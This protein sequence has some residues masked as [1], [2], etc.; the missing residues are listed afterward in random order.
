MKIQ[1]KRTNGTLIA[2]S[3]TLTLKELVENNKANLV[4]A[5]LGGADLVD[6]NLVGAD[7]EDAYLE[8]A[9]LEGADLGSANL[10]GAYLVSANLG[11]ANLVNANLGGAYLVNAN[12]VNANLGGANLVNADL[13][14]ANLGSAN[15]VNANLGGA[16]LGGA[17]RGKWVLKTVPIQILGL[18]FFVIVFDEHLEIE[19][20]SHS[21]EEWEEF[22]NKDFKSMDSNV[23]K[24][25]TENEVIIKALI[26]QRRTNALS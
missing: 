1:L 20:E 19:C 10:E 15:L 7:L 4:N 2:K 6:A 26:K 13:V 11:S 21:F 22:T 17:K 25:K 23:I 16:N 5:H 8:N 24:F 9:N 18:E 3:D 12:L 14:N